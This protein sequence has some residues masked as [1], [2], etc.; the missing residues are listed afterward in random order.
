MIFL[1][2]SFLVLEGYE[3]KLQVINS[4]TRQSELFLD[5]SLFFF[6]FACVPDDILR[7][8]SI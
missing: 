7:K 6:Y 5:P 2:E 3:L 1:I 8:I 4:A